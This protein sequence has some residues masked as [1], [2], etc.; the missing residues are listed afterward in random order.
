M[1]KFG[2]GEKVVSQNKKHKKRLKDARQNRKAR[3]KKDNKRKKECRKGQH[4]SHIA[5]T[6]K[7]KETTKQQ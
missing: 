7:V 2:V 1:E 3:Q 5:F 4:S 6:Q